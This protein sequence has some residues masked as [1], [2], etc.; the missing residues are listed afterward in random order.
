MPLV[1]RSLCGF[2]E[3]I[4]KLTLER[5]GQAYQRN[6][7]KNLWLTYKLIRIL[8]CL[9]SNGIAAIPYKGPVLAETVYKDL[10]L[11]QFSDL[12][13]LIRAADLAR[14]KRALGE[15]DYASAIHL[16]EAEERAYLAAGY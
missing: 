9:K 7:Q 10:A 1:Y 4:P 5:L 6:A 3:D 2:T 13:I 12:D 15:L 8:D 11:R 14:A 16:S